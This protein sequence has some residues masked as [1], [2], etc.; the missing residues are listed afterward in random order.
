MPTEA[1]TIRA[2]RAAGIPVFGRGI[3]SRLYEELFA[4]LREKSVH[5][6]IGCIALPN[7]KSVA[8][9]EKFG[10]RKAAHFSQVGYK[11]GAWQ[12]VG[13]WQVTLGG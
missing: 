4:S 13:Y 8:L 2:A 12:D 11:F 5:V 7:E 1:V 6:V 3:G 9:H 10:M